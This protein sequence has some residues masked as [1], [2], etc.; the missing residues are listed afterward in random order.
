LPILQVILA[1]EGVS[2]FVIPAKHLE[3]RREPGTKAFVLLDISGF[4]LSPE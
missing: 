1:K 3:V 2:S 4:R